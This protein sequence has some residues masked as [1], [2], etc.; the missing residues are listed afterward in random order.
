[1]ST[2]G[3]YNGVMLKPITRCASVMLDEDGQ[4]WYWLLTYDCGHTERL[5]RGEGITPAAFSDEACP[6]C[7]PDDP[8][9][10]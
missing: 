2:G 8:G 4:S 1:M 6:V 7:W 9:A 10:Y 3:V 5:E